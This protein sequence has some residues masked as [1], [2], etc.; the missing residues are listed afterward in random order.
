[1]ALYQGSA[2]SCAMFLT[3]Q[4]SNVL[5]AGFAAKLAGVT[6]TW[7]SWFVAGLLPGLVSLVAVPLVVMKVLH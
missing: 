2:V 4:A 5:V 1:M 6:V 3:G 7:S